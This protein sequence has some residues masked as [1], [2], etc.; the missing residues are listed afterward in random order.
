MI[1]CTVDVSKAI[2]AVTKL[3]A[4]VRG[5]ATANALNDTIKAANTEAARQIRA[6]GYN[7]KVSKIKE[8]IKIKKA[9][10]GMLIARLIAIDRPVNLSEYGAKPYGKGGLTRDALGRLKFKE[11]GGVKAKVKRKVTTIP[12]GFIAN[13][14][15]Y[16]RMSKSGKKSGGFDAGGGIRFGRGFTVNN[17]DIRQLIG[18][19][20]NQVFANKVIQSVMADSAKAR[21]P[22][23]FAYWIARFDK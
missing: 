15:A 21:F 20:V 22:K 7:I 18:P 2:A 9:T 3:S 19:G 13:G 12:G 23:R 14:K 4:A 11:G 6:E 17:E 1:D 8:R 5:K 10:T 16:I